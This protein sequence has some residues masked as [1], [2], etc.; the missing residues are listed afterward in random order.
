MMRKNRKVSATSKPKTRC[1]AMPYVPLSQS[2][3]APIAST[4][5]RA[6]TLS[7]IEKS[8]Q[9]ENRGAGVRGDEGSSR[10]SRASKRGES[11]ARARSAAERSTER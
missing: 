2:C 4:A 3:L 11:E 1:V 10:S 7:M 9:L 6:A 5:L 8:V